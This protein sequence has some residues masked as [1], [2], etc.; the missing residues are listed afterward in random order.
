MNFPKLHFGRV[1]ARFSRE[2][3]NSV[4]RRNA[5]MLSHWIKLPILA[6][7]LCLAG[8]PHASHAATL[9]NPPQARQRILPTS[10]SVATAQ[11]GICVNAV[12][13]LHSIP[14]PQT[15]I[16]ALSGLATLLALQRF[17]RTR[18]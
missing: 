17:R 13:P 6:M 8:R 10:P 14:E 18:S 4:F 2:D 15:W 3:R 12:L 16:T 5:A 11:P 7:A 1:A 9:S